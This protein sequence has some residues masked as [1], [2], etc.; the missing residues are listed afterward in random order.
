[1]NPTKPTTIR[2][3]GYVRRSDDQSNRATEDR[4]VARQQKDIEALVARKGWALVRHYEEPDGT[5]GDEFARRPGLHALLAD[6]TTK[7]F[8]VVVVFEV[9]RLAR[10]TSKLLSIVED[11]QDAGIEVWAIAP[12]EKKVTCRAQELHPPSFPS[13]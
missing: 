7:A 1:M 9:E 5:K 2:A 8:G 13:A 12:S 11:L 10:R 4:S 6:A 3:V